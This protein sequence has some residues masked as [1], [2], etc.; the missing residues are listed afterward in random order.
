M[1]YKLPIATRKSICYWQIL[2]VLRNVYLRL[3]EMQPRPWI[4]LL[5]LVYHLS[6][7][8]KIQAQIARI[9]KFYALSL[10]LSPEC[11]LCSH[12]LLSL[13]HQQA[14]H[15]PADSKRSISCGPSDPTLYHDSGT[16]RTSHFGLR[17]LCCDLL[18]F[19]FYYF[20]E[21]KHWNH[22]FVMTQTFESIVK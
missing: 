11:Y 17:D 16:S 5:S 2:E 3:C 7:S 14:T 15:T 1:R 12:N 13:D 9:M 10:Q 4:V 19:I 20:F 22:K 8:S 6:S 21:K 18:N